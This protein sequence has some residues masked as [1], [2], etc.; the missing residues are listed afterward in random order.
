M[1]CT[2]CKQRWPTATLMR[3]LTTPAALLKFST[4]WLVLGSVFQPRTCIVLYCIVAGIGNVQDGLHPVQEALTNIHSTDLSTFAALPD[5]SLQTL[6]TCEMGCTL[7]RQHWPTAAAA[8][9]ASAPW[10]RDEHLG[11]MHR[12]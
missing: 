3:L 2:Q 6:A 9:V 8:S 4:C 12:V 10:L 11:D 5:F 7:C 1:G